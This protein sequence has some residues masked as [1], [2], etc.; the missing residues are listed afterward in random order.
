MLGLYKVTDLDSASGKGRFDEKGLE[1]N[2][3]S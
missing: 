3:K 2:M 1:L